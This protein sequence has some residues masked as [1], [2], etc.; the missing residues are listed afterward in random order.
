MA[1]RDAGALRRRDLGQ[2]RGRGTDAG[3]A[4]AARPQQRG[5]AAPAT[6]R[7]RGRPAAVQAASLRRRDQ[8]WHRSCSPVPTR[9][10]SPGTAST[11]EQI[12]HAAPARQLS[13]ASWH[14]F[15]ALEW[16]RQGV[17]PAMS[18]KTK[19]G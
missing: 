10:R 8:T 1:R 15:P 5:G 13:C 9:A 19:N 2:A 16:F 6:Q 3:A 4:A 7:E 14:A 11:T 18:A 17:A 12:R